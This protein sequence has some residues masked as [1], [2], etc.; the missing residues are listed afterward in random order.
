MQLK[1]KTLWAELG[2]HHNGL[3]SEQPW[4][5]VGVVESCGKLTYSA[6]WWV[7]STENLLKNSRVIN[8]YQ[9][10]L[11]LVKY[12]AGAGLRTSSAKDWATKHK[13]VCLGS[14]LLDGD[15]KKTSLIS[16]RWCS[17]CLVLQSCLKTLF[18]V[19]KKTLQLYHSKV[20]LSCFL[21]TCHCQV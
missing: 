15:K 8:S 1:L 13:N 2:A 12:V 19:W 6:N 11:G 5:I 7:L 16:M 3:L 21:T 18:V 4:F 9:E 17:S 14:R 10:A 20:D